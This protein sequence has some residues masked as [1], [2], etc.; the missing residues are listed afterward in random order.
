MIN[1]NSEIAAIDELLSFPKN[2]IIKESPT[3]T[4]ARTVLLIQNPR[5]LNLLLKE[6]ILR[7][8]DQQVEKIAVNDS[9][10]VEEG[11]TPRFWVRS[12]DDEGTSHVRAKSWRT[13]EDLTA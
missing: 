8:L 5:L 13:D 11:K 6:Y 10:L 7:L 12:V 4:Q 3:F 9:A 1:L 2:S